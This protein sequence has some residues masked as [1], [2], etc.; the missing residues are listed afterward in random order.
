MNA[1]TCLEISAQS[2]APA[3]LPAP[4]PAPADK[5]KEYTEVPLESLNLKAQDA[6]LN[7][8]STGKFNNVYMSLHTK[9]G[10]SGHLNSRLTGIFFFYIVKCICKCEIHKD[11]I[12]PV[13]M[14]HH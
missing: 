8:E 5:D 12:V 4:V 1:Q 3:P 6:L 7:P 11:Y 2:P 10:D 13:L 9:I 14:T